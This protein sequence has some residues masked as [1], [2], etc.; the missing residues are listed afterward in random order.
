MDIVSGL[1]V[2]KS[3]YCKILVIVEY[4]TKLIKI[5]P[6]IQKSQ[7]EVAEKLWLFISQFGPPKIILSDQGTEFVNKTIESLLEKTGIE[8]EDLPNESVEIEKILDKRK[9]SGNQKIEYLV[10][11]KDLNESENQWVP[12]ENFDELKIIQDFNQNLHR[13]INQEH[14]SPIEKAAK[15]GR[16]RPK[17][18]IP[19]LTILLNLFI[20]ITLAACDS[21]NKFMIF[22]KYKKCDRSTDKIV[23]LNENCIVEDLT[24]T[25]F[26]ELDSYLN[27]NEL[28]DLLRS[29]SLI[30]KSEPVIKQLAPK[31]AEKE[32]LM[33]TKMYILAKLHDEISGQGYQCEMNKVKYILTETLF[34]EKYP[35][36]LSQEKLKVDSETCWHMIQN[37]I[38]DS[39]PLKCLNNLCVTLKPTLNDK[40]SWW[41]SKII[42]YTDCQFKKIQINAENKNSSLFTLNWQVFFSIR[43]QN[44]KI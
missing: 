30:E 19:I 4:M 14:V 25:D 28:A 42:E 36:I 2:T 37:R 13:D 12:E 24:V 9:N 38:C 26:P 15:R 44:T 32:A 29:T 5:Y 10:K 16:G 7:N 1:P 27:V 43:T 33:E 6:L 31:T 18:T 23:A 35:P 39:R 20:I 34:G 17:R 40:Y 22:E 41:Q 11:W 3:G 8:N 21:G